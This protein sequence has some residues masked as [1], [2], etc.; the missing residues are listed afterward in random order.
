VAPHPRYRGA[1][2]PQPDWADHL[3]LAVPFPN[4]SPRSQNTAILGSPR[5]IQPEFLGQCPGIGL[6]FSFHK[7]L[8]H[9][10]CWSWLLLFQTGCLMRTISSPIVPSVDPFS[11][12]KISLKRCGDTCLGTP[13][14]EDPKFK[15]WGTQWILSQPVLHSETLSQTNKQQQK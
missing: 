13:R 14:Q 4:T 7:L 12:M 5:S 6:R 1:H 3:T 15:A 11:Y 10:N 9:E 2:G 8:G